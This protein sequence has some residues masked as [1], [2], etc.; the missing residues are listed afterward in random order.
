MSLYSSCTGLMGTLQEIAECTSV[1]M[2]SYPEER[3]D[4]CRYCLAAAFSVYMKVGDLARNKPAKIDDEDWERMLT[5]EEAWLGKPTDAPS[6]PALLSEKEHLVL[7]ECAGKEFQVLQMWALDTSF[8]VY[9]H[10]AMKNGVSD[11]QAYLQYGRFEDMVLKLR[12]HGASITNTLDMPVPFPYYH[13]LVVI[14]MIN[15]MLYTF[16]FLD[17]NSY[18]T[19]PAIFMIIFVTTALRE[20]SS[21][22]ANPFGDDE[23]DF[24]ISKYMHKKRK[25]ISFLAHSHTWRLDAYQWT[26]HPAVAVAPEVGAR[27]AAH[28][29]DAVPPAAPPPRPA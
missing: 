1:T 24:N 17:I 25:L 28:S 26:P 3:W 15:Y 23:V 8:R 18:I 19:P 6:M 4:V 27:A 7:K 21:A 16:A 9:H 2:A 20:L 29:A 14:M 10:E 5:S 13:V 11:T 22:L 12:G